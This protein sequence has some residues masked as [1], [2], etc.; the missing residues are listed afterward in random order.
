MRGA[1]GRS[2]IRALSSPDPIAGTGAAAQDRARLEAALLAREAELSGTTG[3]ATARLWISVADVR[4]T[5]LGDLEGA[6]KALEL[7]R[8]ADPS[9]PAVLAALRRLAIRLWRWP[10][11]ADVLAAERKL[12]S[13]PERSTRTL[14]LAEIQVDRLGR[15]DEA[16]VLL[17]EVL[18][19]D[20][21]NA[22]ALARAVPMWTAASAWSEMAQAMEAAADAVRALDANRAG[23]LFYAAGEVHRWRLHAPPR[24]AEAFEKAME[25]D[26][27]AVAP[28]KA[29]AETASELRDW[30]RLAKA[31]ERE[32]ELG[33]GGRETAAAALTKLGTLREDS[34]G[35]ADGAEAAWRLA[36]EKDPAHRPA[37]AA[38]A[39]V[40]ERR[41]DHALL[42]ELREKELLQATDI[43]LAVA[44]SLALGQI[45]EERL[46][47]LDRAATQF[48]R[49]LAVT[50]TEAPAFRALGRLMAATGQWDL[51]I[52]LYE[53]EAAETTDEVHRLHCLFKIAEIYEEKVGDDRKAQEGYWR[54]LEISATFL[55][56]LRAL[57]RIFQ[58]RE[59]WSSLVN[60][61]LREAEAIEDPSHW[62]DVMG[63]VSVLQEEK[64][65]ALDAAAR[66]WELVLGKMPDY[67]PALR[68]LARLHYRRGDWGA[69]VAINLR[70]A[71][72]TKDPQAVA[73]LLHKTGEIY[74]DRLSVAEDA[75]RCYRGALDHVPN[76]LPAMRS[77]GRLAARRG[78]WTE[79][80]E[81]ELLE[82]ENVAD[83]KRAASLLN[84]AAEHYEYRL[85][86]VEAAIKTYERV[87]KTV[88]GYL[89]ATA[90]LAR[91][92]RKTERWADLIRVLESSVPSLIRDPGGAASVET[93][94]A[95]I[96]GHRLGNDAAAQQRITAARHM[97]PDDPHVRRELE[98]YLAKA[99]SWQELAGL[100]AE[101]SAAAPPGAM[102]AGL[103]VRMGDLSWR[104]GS[105]ADAPKATEAY[106]AALLAD[107]GNRAAAAGLEDIALTTNDAKLQVEALMA[108][109]LA[110]RT[111]DERRAILVTLAR[112]HEEAGE[113]QAAESCWSAAAQ[114]APDVDAWEAL[115]RG[116]R[117]AERHVA[118]ADAL[119]KAIGEASDPAEKERLTLEAA[120][121]LAEGG[122]MEQAE[123]M[124][125]GVAA[126]APEPTAALL[127]LERVYRTLAARTEP[128]E[129]LVQGKLAD[130]LR[131][132]A[133]LTRDSAR[134]TELSVEAAKTLAGGIGREMEAAQILEQV[135]ESEPAGSPAQRDAL[136][137][138]AE[139]AGA[140]GDR[141]RQAAS[142]ERLAEGATGIARAEYLTAAGKVLVD[143]DVDRAITCWE[144]AVT[145]DPNATA[146]LDALIETYRAREAWQPLLTTWNRVIGATRDPKVAAQ[147]YFEKGVLLLERMR[148]PDKAE[149]HFQ[150]SLSAM[151][152]FAPA[153]S[154]LSVLY[155]EQKNIG[156]ERECLK[157][158]VALEAGPDIKAAR[159]S[160]LA[161]SCEEAGDKAAA[162]AALQEAA[163]LAPGDTSLWDRILALQSAGGAPTDKVAAL[164][165]ALEATQDETRKVSLRVGLAQALE[166]KGD[167]V[168]ALTHAGAAVKAAPADV[169]ARAAVARLLAKQ[170]GSRAEA[171][172]AHA[173]V[174]RLDP[175]RSESLAFLARAYEEAK[176][177]D[178][179]LL[180]SALVALTGSG[181]GSD[182]EIF[183][184]EQMPRAP[185]ESK[186]PIGFEDRLQLLAAPAARGKAGEL[187]AR[188]DGATFRG[189]PA[190]LTALG[191]T[192]AITQGHALF[193]SL[194]GARLL[195]GMPE[196]TAVLARGLTEPARVI[197]GDPPVIALSASLMSATDGVRRFLIARAVFRFATGWYPAG[198]TAAEVKSD[199]VLAAGALEISAP[200]QGTDSKV[201]RAIVK[202]IPRKARKEIVELLQ[203]FVEKP[204]AFDIEAFLNGADRSADRAGLLAC[205]DLADAV[206]AL[207]MVVPEAGTVAAPTDTRGQVLMRTPAGRDLLVFAASDDLASLRKRAGLSIV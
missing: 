169:E 126:S 4:A 166:E 35:D 192:E 45:Y 182:A 20:P 141:A 53:R 164:E 159:L 158:L 92:Y 95:T 137:K 124:L 147:G 199:L 60:L 148:L 90:G 75:I 207:A 174:L 38:L 113:A 180:L 28:V 109:S 102:R 163:A 155:R 32:A 150:R 10:L 48:Q 198:R 196:A 142:L 23:A 94:I 73:A 96:E 130:V 51:L 99:G 120:N 129:P 151:P 1:E 104:A 80:V 114:I 55:P 161:R 2:R 135:A 171:M 5:R 40:A 81:T 70:E 34:L 162:L 152:T 205:V 190:D 3:T 43:R 33:G 123:A 139:I 67:L 194:Q 206:T 18:D 13:G 71:T 49:V 31:L 176:Q 201:L 195:F 149:Q 144:R 74:E 101:A 77:L 122:E 16:L 177:H 93:E 105:A 165:Q 160:A 193:T 183:Y 110:A 65:G 41:G 204:D 11:A 89:P 178:R 98:E 25:A 50:Q 202:A 59:D 200:P 186:A 68:A 189:A 125:T 6:L 22:R 86:D 69:L 175:L 136:T 97:L 56:A 26:P 21:G 64:L 91:L 146:A 127:S 154:R 9:S 46:G 134:R 156:A 145:A 119:A 63:R 52:K 167:D 118:A 78:A 66:T 168:A 157:R 112:L 128:P 181:S 133:A 187:L 8:S 115:A 84:S 54:V 107:P 30:A 79:V 39:R 140:T 117:R 188:L 111:R 121:D 17:S 76:F 106:R 103:Q 143:M 47:A 72:L 197:P 87:L 83:A 24:A 57:G 82:A 7:A 44:L 27:T 58:R 29:L 138:L 132:L 61:Y 170:K 14:E 203:A 184:R 12:L 191:P 36:L 153:L 131:R 108:S 88:P 42:A 179:V 173:A 37:L 100:Y 116:A 19:G 85:G 62:L 172:D 185:R 15:A